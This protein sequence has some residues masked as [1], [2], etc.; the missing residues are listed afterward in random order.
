MTFLSKYLSEVKTS[1]NRPRRNHEDI[2][3]K[4][5]AR[6]KNTGRALCS[7]RAVAFDPT[8]LEDMHKYVLSNCGI[9]SV[10]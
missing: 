3:T 5:V 1:L 8:E 10:I 4:F 7:K 9:L 6:F 2:N